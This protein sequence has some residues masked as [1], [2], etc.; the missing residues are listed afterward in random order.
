MSIDNLFAKY[1]AFV[2]R[3][4]P[5]V[6]QADF[7]RIC[8]IEQQA[9]PAEQWFLSECENMEEF[10]QNID[11]FNPAQIYCLFGDDWYLLAVR[12]FYYIELWGFAAASKKC[13]GIMKAISYLFENFSRYKVIADCRAN[14]SY[15]LIMAYARKGRIRIMSDEGHIIDRE[16]FRKITMKAEKRKRCRRR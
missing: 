6:T 7:E 5:I 14:T 10:L 1:I 8:A 4:E 12:H 2:R 13:L 15:P 3:K 9:F 11:C 16:M